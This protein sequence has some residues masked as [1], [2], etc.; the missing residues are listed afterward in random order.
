LDLAGNFED[1]LRM[2]LNGFELSPLK[3]PLTH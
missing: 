2:A 3:G 1:T